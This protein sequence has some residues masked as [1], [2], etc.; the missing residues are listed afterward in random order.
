MAR[1][2]AVV[3]YQADKGITLARIRSINNKAITAEDN[4]PTL[5]LERIATGLTKGDGLLLEVEALHQKGNY[6][7]ASNAKIIDSKS[8]GKVLDLSS[9]TEESTPF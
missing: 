9:F 7:S 6:L 2:E 8:T 3:N 4:M 1:I 5:R